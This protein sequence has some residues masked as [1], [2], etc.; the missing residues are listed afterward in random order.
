MTILIIGCNGQVGTEL[1]I[2]MQKRGQEIIAVDLPEMD[3][4]D[5]SSV[6]KYV[7]M[8]GVNL[9]I[10]AAAYTAVDR[11]ESEEAPAFAVNATGPGLIAE[12]AKTRNIPFIHISTDYVFDGTKNSPYVET[13]PVSPAGVYG[14]SKAKGDM[15]V[16]EHM[17]KH[18]ILRTSW[19]CSAHGANFVKTMLR[20]GREK[21]V[22]R[23]VDDQKGCP[24]FAQDIA[25]AIV[26]IAERCLA[27][28]EIPWGIYHYCGEEATSWFGFAQEIF[29]QAA[30]REALTLKSLLPIP[31]SEYPLPARRPM[32][33]VL[34]CTKI[35]QN[36]S[37][38][39]KP[40]K[41]SLQ[42]TLTDLYHQES[43]RTHP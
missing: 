28:Q 30:K 34:D 26:T 8:P 32:N 6:K 27:D 31:T 18:I 29:R 38:H 23:V 37:I 15:L 12:C 17:E 9:V 22:I 3:I 42:K 33:S 1:R 11:A 41:Q 24:S 40:W 5:A 4:T 19:V 14:K 16:A 21:E 20:L 25:E 43:D 39:P 35:I 36:F 13:D 2:Q 7:T 10:N